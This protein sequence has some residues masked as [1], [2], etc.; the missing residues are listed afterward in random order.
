MFIKSKQ[1]PWVFLLVGFIAISGLTYVKYKNNKQ[2]SRVQY[3]DNQVFFTTLPSHYSEELL[4]DNSRIYIAKQ[5]ITFSQFQDFIYE[6]DYVTW[7]E[8][9]M[10]YPNWRYPNLHTFNPS[11]MELEQEPNP[12]PNSPV[13]WLTP[14]DAKSYCQWVALRQDSLSPYDRYTDLPAW[15]TMGCR[16]PTVKE[17]ESLYEKLPENFTTYWEWTTNT[18]EEIKNPNSRARSYKTAWKPKENL[19]HRRVEDLG[20]K[21]EEKTCFRV[22]WTIEDLDSH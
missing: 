7:R 10:R 1:L 6:T 20:D 21:E 17:L 8:S 2:V 14:A 12:S 13:L 5:P 22:A 19:R 4:C 18:L 11:L 16:L 3:V 9:N 15:K